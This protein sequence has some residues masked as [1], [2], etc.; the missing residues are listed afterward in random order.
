MSGERQITLTVC[1][2]CGEVIGVE[3]SFYGDLDRVS[4]AIEEALS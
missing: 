1:E 3:A 4:E 2:E